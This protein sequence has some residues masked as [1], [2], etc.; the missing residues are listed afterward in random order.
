MI[1]SWG[2]TGQ[3]FNGLIDEVQVWDRAL[4]ET[5][6]LQS[7]EDLTKLAVDNSGKISVAWGK[8]KSSL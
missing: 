8:I 4:T 2:A 6:I 5:E 7:M 3:K 1:G